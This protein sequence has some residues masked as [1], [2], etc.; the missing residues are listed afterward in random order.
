MT[1][2]GPLNS[3]PIAC[4]LTPE[5]GEEQIKRWRAFNEGHALSVERAGN[6][7]T[8]SYRKTASSVE[9]LRKLVAVESTCCSFVDWRIDEGHRDLRLIV[10]GAP[11]QLAA[12]SIE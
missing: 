5:A 2:I 11:E 4:T 3:L 12:I 7:L 1:H 9:R 10:T 8:F 6:A